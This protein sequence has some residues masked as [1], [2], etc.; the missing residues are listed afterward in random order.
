MDQENN[1]NNRL[2]LQIQSLR[3]GNRTAIVSTLQELRT[4]GNISILPELFELLLNQEE[5]QIINEISSLL[6]D[7]KDEEAVPVLAEAIE[8]PDYSAIVQI[9]VSVCWQNGLAYGKYINTFADVV[10]NGQYDSAIEA[11]TVIE[12]AVGDLDQEERQGLIGRLKSK[13]NVVSVEKKPL[14][15]ELIKVVA[16]Y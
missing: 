6:C 11:F 7:L 8:N 14:L 16:N 3:S 12:E 4:D 5:K 10:T 13:V 1:K 2:K 9:L 15:S